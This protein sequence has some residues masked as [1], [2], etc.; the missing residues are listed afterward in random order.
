MNA[1]YPRP[2]APSHDTPP[3]ESPASE[4]LSAEACYAMVR[5]RDP[6]ADGRFVYA[7]RTTGVYCRPSCSARPARR[8]NLSFHATCAEAE[9][10]GFRACL[11]CAPAGPS[12]DERHAKLVARACA[13]L[14][15]SDPAPTLKDLAADVGLS[16]H[17][18]LRVFRAQ[19]GLT[20]GAYA[21]G[22]RAERARAALGASSSVTE[23]VYAAGYGAPSRFYAEAAPRFGMTPSTYRAG[24]TGVAVRFATAPCPLGWVLAAQTG[25]GICAILLGDTPGALEADLRA[26]L[27]KARIEADD[28][29]LAGALRAVVRLVEQPGLGL[30]LPL[31]VR[32]T[33]FQ[34]RV[35]AAIR[36]IPAGTQA[37]YAEVAEAA[38]APGAARAVARACAANAL[39]IAIPCH[40]VVRAD[41]A[42]SGYRW[43]PARRAALLARERAQPSDPGTGPARRGR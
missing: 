38:G 31:D 32:G 22:V 16:A 17:H 24:G 37:T 13:R 40:R 6:A 1:I 29:A 36:D 42:P 41:G 12:R 30:E 39:A 33:A 23:A 43:G 28:G 3:S 21:R 14:E 19:T 35:W 27:P 7:V 26:R 9:A 2:A 20:P 25:Q 11:R 15:D 34:Q 8:E 4:P 10:A 18:F 5:R